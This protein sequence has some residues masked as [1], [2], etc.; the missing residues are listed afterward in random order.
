MTVTTSTS[1]TTAADPRTL[2]D[3]E[4]F[5]KMVDYFAADVHVTRAY[6][7]RAVEQFLIFQA[8]QSTNGWVHDLAVWTG[9]W[10]THRS[11]AG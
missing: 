11:R 5:G 6:A 3:P 4:T 8:E 2:V 9:E 10:A 7:E 1:R